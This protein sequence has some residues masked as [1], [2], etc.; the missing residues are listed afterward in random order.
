VCLFIDIGTNG[1]VM[2]G[3]RD[4]LIAASASTGPALEGASA[5]CGMRAQSGAVEK[6]YIE[7][8]AIKYD[9]IDKSPA[10][11]LCG[12]GI[13][14]LIAVLLQKQI[15]N[16]SGK[17][18]PA[19]DKKIKA[20]NGINRYVL[21]ENP[22]VYISEIDIENIITAKAAVYAAMKI[23]LKRM[24]IDFSGIARFYIAGAFGS[25]IDKN[26]AIAIGLIPPVAHEKI[27]FSGNT[28]MEGAVMAALN[29]DFFK[30]INDIRNKT[31]YYDL[32]AADD[33]IEEFRRAMFLPHT[34]IG[35]FKL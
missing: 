13:I 31:T 18:V 16:R 23:L 35:D 8:N 10:S 7:N 12:S 22:D 1:E 34:D 33:Y 3:C 30:E 6:V 5:E 14:D 26:N 19:A 15:I 17:F 20:V 29:Y 28:A 11:G 21:S 27:I 9:T 2:L 24:D 4:W 32:M 25:H